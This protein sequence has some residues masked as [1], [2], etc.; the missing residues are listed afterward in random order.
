M[1]GSRTPE[2]T[3]AHRLL[4]ASEFAHTRNVELRRDEGAAHA[5]TLLVLRFI[6]HLPPAAC[7]L[8]TGSLAWAAFAWNAT[9]VSC[10][11]GWREHSDGRNVEVPYPRAS[12]K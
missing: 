6:V 10:S 1:F 9:G 12:W 5:D 4:A 11:V 7:S 3:Y 2:R 8:S